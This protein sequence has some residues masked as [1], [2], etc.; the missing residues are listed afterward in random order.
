MSNV[1]SGAEEKALQAILQ[2]KDPQNSK[3]RLCVAKNNRTGRWA[4]FRRID[5]RS[6]RFPENSERVGFCSRS[7]EGTL[8]ECLTDG[9]LLLIDTGGEWL[10]VE[11]TT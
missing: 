2:P 1:L 3:H 11:L 8:S 5:R 7:D 9:K 6:S 4:T 10:R